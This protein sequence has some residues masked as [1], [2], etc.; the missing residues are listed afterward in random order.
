MSCRSICPRVSGPDG[1]TPLWSHEGSRGSCTAPGQAHGRCSRGLLAPPISWKAVITPRRKTV[2]HYD[3]LKLC[4][5]GTHIEHPQADV[6]EGPPNPRRR[7]EPMQYKMNGS[8]PTATT[9]P[10]CSDQPTME[11]LKP[12]TRTNQWRC[13]NSPQIPLVQI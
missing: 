7:Q 4:S 8:H 5:E 12:Y 13:S 6:H 11:I 2:V 9:R 10:R 3:R 1:Y